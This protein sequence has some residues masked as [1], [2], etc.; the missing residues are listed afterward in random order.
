MIEKEKKPK[1][2]VIS[3]R[4][5]LDDIKNN[6]CLI[7][8]EIYVANDGLPYNPKPGR[9]GFLAA[10]PESGGSGTFPASGPEAWPAAERAHAVFDNLAGVNPGDRSRDDRVDPEIFTRLES[11]L[12]RSGCDHFATLGNKSVAH[13]ADLFSRN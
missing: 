12:S 6:I 2:Q 4:R 3:L 8:R 7:T 13:A 9:D 5:L 1:H 10:P 11:V